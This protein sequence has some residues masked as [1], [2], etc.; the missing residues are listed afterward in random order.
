MFDQ[1][2]AIYVFSLAPSDLGEENI[3]LVWQGS[4]RLEVKFAAN[5]TE[6]LNCL[7]YTEFPALIEMDQSK[8]V[9]YTRA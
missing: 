8:E 7:A 1:G 4:V 2:Y 6:T 9:R 5:T 3:N